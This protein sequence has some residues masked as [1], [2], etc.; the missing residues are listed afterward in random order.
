[1]KALLLYHPQSEHSRIVEEYVR[2]FERQRN[3][4]IKLES[5]DTPEGADKAR[6]YDIVQYPALIVVR[7]DGQLMKD[8]QG[9]QLP[10]MDEVAGY[11]SR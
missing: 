5:L 1:M 3:L 4:K 8:W 2:D 6:L 10:L 9:D 7:D 11:L